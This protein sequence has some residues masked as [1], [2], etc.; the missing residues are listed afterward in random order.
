MAAAYS[1]AKPAASSFFASI[2]VS[3]MGFLMTGRG[4]SELAEAAVIAYLHL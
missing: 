4:K 1:G 2:S 3:I